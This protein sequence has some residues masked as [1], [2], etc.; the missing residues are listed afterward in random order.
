MMNGLKKNRA[1][2]KPTKRADTSVQGIVKTKMEVAEED[3][4]SLCPHRCSIH[5]ALTVEF[6]IMK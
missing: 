4:D 1:R 2:D 5:Y 3:N 6:T